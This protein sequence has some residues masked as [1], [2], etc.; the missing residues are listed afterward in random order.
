MSRVLAALV[1]R[2]DQAMLIAFYARTKKSGRK[3]FLNVLLFLLACQA[4]L[5][6]AAAFNINPVKFQL[7]AS[8][9]VAVMQISNPTDQPVRLQINV[10]DWTTDGYKEVLTDTD[11]LLVNPPIFLLPPNKT[12]YVRFGLRTSGDRNHNI[13][14]CY[15]LVVEEVPTEAPTNGL[16]T[17]LR[18]SL[19]VFFSPKEKDEQLIWKLKKQGQNLMLV[20]ANDGNIHAKINAV[21]LTEDGT[22]PLLKVSTPTYVLPGQHK[23]WPVA[24]AQ[25][26]SA[27]YRL[28]IQTEDGERKEILVQ[29]AE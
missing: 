29:G 23:E 16:R 12:Q 28:E 20:A 15:R 9:A 21:S 8:D 13:E 10:L 17:L 5:A 1:L 2:H 19:P 14:K 25:N 6:C 24:P 7:N 3:F 26:L 27:K 4:V 22:K 18:F 11:D